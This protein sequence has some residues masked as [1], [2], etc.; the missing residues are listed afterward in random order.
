MKILAIFKSPPLQEPLTLT[1]PKK[2][3]YL[4]CAT[5]GFALFLSGILWLWEFGAALVI[6]AQLVTGRFAAGSR[7]MF[8]VGCVMVTLM[9]SSG[10]WM[11][12]EAWRARHVWQRIPPPWWWMVFVVF[13]WLMACWT[14]LQRKPK[15]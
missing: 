9:I 5:L 10:I 6:A 8:C 12:S 7:F 11:F 1:L 3:F 14:E 13:A 2:V 4:A 15:R